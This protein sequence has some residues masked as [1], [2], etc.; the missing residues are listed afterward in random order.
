VKKLLT[1]WRKFLAEGDVKY[2]GILKI[3]PTPLVISELEALQVILPEE[4]I[5]LPKKALH[6]TLIHQSVLSPFKKQIKNMEFPMPPPIILEDEIWRR[7]SPGKISW[8]VRLENQ[9]EMREYVEQIMEML[10][11]PNT[12]PEPER[13]FHISLANLTGNP[14]DSVR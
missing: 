12:D 1:E 7:E 3:N 13:V 11:S 2:S 6:I 8:A 4:A 14:K 9:D 5:R 10:E